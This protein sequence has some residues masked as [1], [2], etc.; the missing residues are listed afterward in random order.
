MYNNKKILAF[1]PSRSGS[2]RIKN[3][4]T[5]KLLNKPLFQYSVEVAKKS[6]YIDDIIVSS[7]SLETLELSLNLGCIKNKVR[8]ME[9][10]SDNARIID[11][12]CYEIKE[13]NL[14]YDAV[15]LLQPTSPIRTAEILDKAIIEYFK[16]ETSLITVRKNK[17]NPLF[18]RKVV[19]GKLEKILSDSSD[20][21]S[22]DFKKYYS[23]VGNMYINNF[24]Y[25]NNNVILN[26]N[27]IPFEI[28]DKYC[29]DIDTEEDWK[30]A[31][32]ILLNLKNK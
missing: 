10:S 31:E 16:T 13:N 27:I 4:N 2:K 15:V 24:N 25:L 20:I 26:E 7:D 18:L 23:I 30:L 14:V 3:K 19:D 6:K 1:I 17:D 9:L 5:R 29:V 32:K 11:A 22:Q 28:E 8:P 12:I 21:R